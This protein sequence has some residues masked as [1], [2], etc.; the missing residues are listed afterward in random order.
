MY[1][2]QNA[3]NDIIIR[4]ENTNIFLLLVAGKFFAYVGIVIHLWII[5]K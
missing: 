4:K 2:N 3:T 1:Y 5:V